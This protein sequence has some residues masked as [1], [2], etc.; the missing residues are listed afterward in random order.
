MLEVKDGT[1]ARARA[2]FGGMA[3]TPKR[4]AACEA[5]LAGQP[6][7][8]ATIEAAVGALAQDFEP[9]DDVRGTREYR[10]E[11]AANLLR[12]LWLREEGH[13]ISVLEIEA[14]DG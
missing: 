12:R 11:A 4:A 6:F 13:D 7:G 10:L 9:L 1:I 2:A 8:S 3:A 14:V 5:A